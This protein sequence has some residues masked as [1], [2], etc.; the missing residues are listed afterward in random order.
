MEGREKLTKFQPATIGQ[1]TRIGGVSPADITAL[2]LHI[3]LEAR[4]RRKAAAEAE[5]APTAGR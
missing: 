4:Q 3:E 1:A 2:L 5:E